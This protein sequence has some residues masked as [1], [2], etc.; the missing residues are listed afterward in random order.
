MPYF[1]AQ[2]G[3]KCRPC[4]VKKDIKDLD[5]SPDKF[6]V[7]LEWGPLMS[8]K[9]NFAEKHVVGY[10]VH[11]VDNSNKILMTLDT[12]DKADS[13]TSCCSKALYSISAAGTL[14]AGFHR[15]MIVPLMTVN[16]KT[17]PLPSGILTDVITD[18]AQGTVTKV[19][20][21]FDLEL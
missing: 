1:D 16:G 18:I 2:N 8:T 7:G 20:G 5:V 10:M 12:V 11:I 4:S 9:G 21:S 6:W 14:P 3:V 17:V 15:F 19:K 13:D